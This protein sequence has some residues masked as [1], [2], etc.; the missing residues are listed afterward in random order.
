MCQTSVFSHLSAK[1]ELETGTGVK[2]DEFLHYVADVGNDFHHFE[3]HWGSVYQLC[4]PCEAKF[5]YIAK[6]ETID[7]DSTTILNTIHGKQM[8]YPKRTMGPNAAHKED[9]KETLRKYYSQVDKST[10]ARIRHLYAPDFE[11]FGYDYDS[12]GV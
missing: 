9:A 12:N 1:E 3:P 7:E 8:E 10:L 6:L 4:D 11:L 2:F 5:K